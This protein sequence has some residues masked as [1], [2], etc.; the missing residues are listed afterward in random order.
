VAE[1]RAE[2]LQASAAVQQ[3][4][5][6][7]R[8][9]VAELWQQLNRLQ[10]KQQE[11]D[12]AEQRSELELDRARGEYELEMITD[13]GDAMVDTSRVKYERAK[14]DFEQALAWMN[15]YLLIGEN[16]EKILKHDGA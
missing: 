6:T 9:K 13:L 16:P 1:T 10:I 11:L 8:S 14:N 3:L 2:W 15:L 4:E 5:V 7:L 12:V